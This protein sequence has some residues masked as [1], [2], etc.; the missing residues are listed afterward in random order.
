MFD[1]LIESKKHVNKRGLFGG[2]FVSTMVHAA[3]ITAAAIA[4]LGAKEQLDKSVADTDVIFITPPKP[5]E[6]PPP[7]PPPEEVLA[8]LAPPPKGF[9]TIVP[10][11]EIPTEIPDI[12]LTK[13]FDPRDFTGKGVEGGVAWGVEDSGEAVDLNAT[14]LEAV[15]QERPEQLSCPKPRYPDI[16]RNARIDGRVLLKFIINAD[17]KAEPQSIEVVSS[18]NGAFN[19]PARNA[20]RGCRFRPGRIRGQAVRVLV[21]MPVRFKLIG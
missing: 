20:I 14:F 13:V 8:T 18:D 2:G 9:Q 6:P 4:T 11:S 5:D 21:Q 17:G 3:L 1:T 19:R 10:P 15:V 16:L 7:E 12:D